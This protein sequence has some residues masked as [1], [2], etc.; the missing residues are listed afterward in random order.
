VGKG[1]PIQ[2]DPELAIRFQYQM[3]LKPARLRADTHAGPPT[4][5]HRAD[6]QFL[7]GSHELDLGDKVLWCA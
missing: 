6:S 3:I 4:V 2:N 1:R 7:E 5:D